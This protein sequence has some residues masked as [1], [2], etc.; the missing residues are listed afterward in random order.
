[1]KIRSYILPLLCLFGTL[2]LSL[3]F[4]LN[5][6]LKVADSYA[7]FQ[8]AHNLQNFSQ[9][10]LGNGWFGFVYS[11]PLA[12]LWVIFQNDFL[13]YQVTNLLCL[14][15]SAVLLYC[16][17]RKVLSKNWS[18]IVVLLF[19][20][21]PTLLHFHIHILS[22]NIYIPLFLGLFLLVYN[23]V[24]SFQ[25][26]L[27]WSR[28]SQSVAIG[29]MLGLL[30]LTRAEAFIYMG[31]IGLI[32][33]WM[34]IKKYLSLKTFLKLGTICIASFFI[35]ISP[36]LVHL[37][38]LSGEWGL[39]NK[40]ASN[41]RQAELRGREKMDDA[42]F[43]QAVAE[44]TEDN[45]QLIAG[46]AGGMK[47]TKPQIEWSLGAFIKKDPKQ[48]LSRIWENQ[49]KL[50]TKNIPEIFLGKAPDLYWSES[51]LFGGNILFLIICIIPAV[52]LL[53]GITLA[54]YKHRTFFVLSLAFFIPASLFF[55]LFFTLNRYFLIFLPL[56][57][58][59]FTLAIAHIT[60]YKKYLW[61]SL[62]TLY[63]GLLLL[64]TKVYYSTE[65]PK[66][67]FYFL[68]AQAG[69]WA[70]EHIPQSERSFM[71]RF[72]VVTYYA[73]AN[74]RYITPYTDDL[75]RIIEYAHKNDIAYLVVDT[76]DFL[77][78]R[79]ELKY[80][81]ENTP[82]WLENIFQIENEKWQKVILYKIIKNI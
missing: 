2:Y 76:M 57:L 54:T 43:E 47:Y 48:F 70:Q 74:I 33:L 58:I 65:A 15:I 37:L 55:T 53:Y 12:L 44:L 78:Y 3:F 67:D 52:L 1:M 68:K 23:F 46:F 6:I 61:Y 21:S 45:S 66:N 29:V 16:I 81:L 60:Q 18:Y 41:L 80:L 35:F 4:H 27:S 5:E 71:E 25:K 8:M 39:T 14:N 38:S 62:L 42:G 36:Y 22:E 51:K 59:L 9:S 63:I 17:A 31:S 20:L 19:F 69:V 24:E 82:D 28:I 49:L 10:W 72:P 34:L 77:K 32:A 7:Y 64:S 56:L 75:G 11:L 40:G 79:P 30:Y 26:N 13:A 50:F 73:Q